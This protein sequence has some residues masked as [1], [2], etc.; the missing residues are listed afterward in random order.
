M[1]IAIAFAVVLVVSTFLFH[2]K[3]L[4]TASSLLPKLRTGLE[5]RVLFVILAAFAAHIAEILVYAFAFMVSAEVFELG[6]FGGRP[7]ETILDYL[8]FSIVSF[9]SLGLGD[10]FPNG[11]LRFLAGVE[12]LNGLLLIGWSASFTYLAM[13]RLWPWAECVAP[14]LSQTPH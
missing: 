11:H 5:V 2:Y 10:V 13:G 4:R 1:L 12:A 3:I 9:T 7:V 14:R 6:T 8:Y